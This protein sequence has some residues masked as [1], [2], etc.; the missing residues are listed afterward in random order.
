VIVLNSPS[1]VREALVIKGHLSVYRRTLLLLEISTPSLCSM[2]LK[3][4]KGRRNV[5]VTFCS[6]REALVIRDPLFAGRPEFYR[7]RFGFHFRDDVIFTTD[8]AKWRSMKHLSAQLLRM[9][10]S[11]HDD[12]DVI[13]DELRR[14]DDELTQLRGQSIDP[15]YVLQT[16]VFPAISDL[17]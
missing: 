7:V 13:A 10:L 16:A 5:P 2:Y 3:T 14:L 6:I 8:S 11:C 4:R 1:S 17:Q 9:T 12:N 15:S